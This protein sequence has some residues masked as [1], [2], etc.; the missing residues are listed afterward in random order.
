MT[1]KADRRRGDVLEQPVN[2]VA[3][4]ITLVGLGIFFLLSQ[5]G[6]LTL[7]GNWWT[8]FI[9]IPAFAMLFSAFRAYQRE[10]AITPEVGSN[11]SG[12]VILAGIA[13]LLALNRPEFLLPFLLIAVGLFV[14]MGLRRPESR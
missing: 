5:T 11:I 8:I 12:G 6:V 1:Q 13:L 4:G 3:V 2:R 10:G 9:A 14:V 7:Q